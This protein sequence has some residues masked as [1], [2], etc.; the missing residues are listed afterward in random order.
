MAASASC[1]NYHFQLSYEDGTID[2]SSLR[3]DIDWDGYRAI[4]GFHQ[5]ISSSGNTQIIAN[6]N[7]FDIDYDPDGAEGKLGSTDGYG[8]GFGLR[9]MV[10]EQRRTRRHDQLGQ[11]A[12][13]MQEFRGSGY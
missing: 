4:L 7:Y 9:S 2:D 8:L 1:E 6:I 11:M 13:L 12:A 10:S 3:I 5:A